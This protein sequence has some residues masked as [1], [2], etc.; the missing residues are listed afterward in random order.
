MFECNYSFGYF[1]FIGSYVYTCNAKNRIPGDAK[2]LEAIQGNHL[3][4][5]KN[6]DVEVLVLVNQTLPHIPANVGK[7]F[8]YIKGIYLYDM[9]LTLSSE[10]LKQFPQLIAFSAEMCKFSSLDDNLFEFTPNLQKISFFNSSIGKI[11]KDLLNNL[12]DLESVNFLDMP[13]VNNFADT[14]EEIQELNNT[15]EECFN[16]SNLSQTLP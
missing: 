13:C 14:P 1:E 2:T 4:K 5:Q 3:P 6:I 7:F 15:L 9:A 8:K 16:Y 11:G 10:D 12:N